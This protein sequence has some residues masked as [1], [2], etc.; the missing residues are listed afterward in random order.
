MEIGDMYIY[1]GT[2]KTLY[3]VAWAHWYI[4]W[5]ELSVSHFYNVVT[6]G[7]EH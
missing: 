1:I 5:E 6:A 3:I 7:N 2:C 4:M